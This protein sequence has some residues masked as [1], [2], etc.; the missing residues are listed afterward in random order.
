LASKIIRINMHFIHFALF[1]F[2]QLS[3]TQTTEAQTVQTEPDLSMTKISEEQQQH[4]LIDDEIEKSPESL[5]LSAS[6]KK[7]KL[8]KIYHFFVIEALKK[9]IELSKLLSQEKKAKEDELTMI[10]YGKKFK[11]SIC[12][13][14]T[15]RFSEHMMHHANVKKYICPLCKKSFSHSWTIKRHLE[16]FHTI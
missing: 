16:K 4:I 2:F 15:K 7:L 12:Q 9:R 14:V 1:F 6:E 8:K 13:K 3:N 5:D 10:R 11:C